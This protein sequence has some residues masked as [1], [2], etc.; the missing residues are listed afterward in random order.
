MPSAVT[1]RAAMFAQ[2]RAGVAELGLAPSAA[3]V[4]LLLDYVELLARWNA[5]YNLTAVRDPLAMVTNHL[6]DSLAVAHLV[7]GE[8][9]ADVGSGAGLP[10]I[11]LAITAPELQVTLIDANGKKTRFLREAVRTLALGNVRIEAQRV[12]RV[13]GLF[14]TVIARAFASLPDMLRL[15]GHLLAPDGILLALKGQL[16]K[17]EVVSLPDGFVIADVKPLRVPGLAAARHAVII[18]RSTAAISDHAA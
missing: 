11:P 1:D 18:Q 7:R 16:H 2:L 6:L 10:G 13:H 14:D 5:V 3:A 12:E 15:A 17:D 9:L 4:E 8:R